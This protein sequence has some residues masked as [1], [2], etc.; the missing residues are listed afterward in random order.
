M[1]K[2]PQTPESIFAAFT[3]DYKNVFGADLESVILY[4]SAARGEYIHK[5]SDIN[6]MIVLTEPGM[7]RLASAMPLVAKWR[8]SHVATPLFLTQEYIMSSL[9]VFPIEFLNMQAAY[10]VV[11][12]RDV[13]KNLAF[14]KRLVRLQAERELKAKLL[15]L[16]QRFVETG[17]GAKKITGL[18]S[19]SLPAFA[20]IFQAV[21]FLQDKGPYTRM[22]DL[23]AATAAATGLSSVLFAALTSVR[24]KTKKLN[25]SEALSLMESYIKEVKTLAMHIDTF[26]TK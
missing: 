7:G 13:L 21:L 11:W 16:Q 17:G 1:A 5:V 24:K 2:A 19:L 8:K 12:G 20:S 9:D 23:L 25:D 14:D 22:A 26:N 6:F 3:A 4:G 10:Q 18:I 15:Q